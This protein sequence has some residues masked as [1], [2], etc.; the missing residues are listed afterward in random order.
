MWNGKNEG[1][2]ALA[3]LDGE[4]VTETLKDTH[5][6]KVAKTHGTSRPQD[7]VLGLTAI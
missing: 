2:S 4:S 7:K 1:E 5:C 6:D 3:E